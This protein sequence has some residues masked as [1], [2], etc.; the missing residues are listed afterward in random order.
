[1]NNK[2]LYKPIKLKP[3]KATALVGAKCMKKAFGEAAWG[4]ES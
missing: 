1:M 2:R 4:D 3:S